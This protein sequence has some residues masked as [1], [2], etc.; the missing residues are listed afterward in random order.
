M[1]SYFENKRIIQLVLA[2]AIAPILLGNAFHLLLPCTQEATSC[3]TERSHSHDEGHEGD[4]PSSP[5]SICPVC[6][7]LAMPR[8][9]AAIVTWD[10]SPTLVEQYVPQTAELFITLYRSFERGRAPP[11]IA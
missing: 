5:E 8:D 7:F 3:C 6:D 1:N 10:C 9:V 11:V 2:L 4:T